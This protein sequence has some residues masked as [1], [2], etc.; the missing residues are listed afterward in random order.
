MLYLGKLLE[1]CFAGLT[2]YRG[3]G[4]CCAARSPLPTTDG[5]ADAFSASCRAGWWWRRRNQSIGAARSTWASVRRWRT[6]LA[7]AD[8]PSNQRQRFQVEPARTCWIRAGMAVASPAA[9]RVGA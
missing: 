6:R 2:V 7:P 1:G 5:A 9:D 8:A 3:S 4:A